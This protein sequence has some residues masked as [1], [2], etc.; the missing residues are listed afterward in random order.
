M[1]Y[2]WLRGPIPGFNLIKSSGTSYSAN[3]WKA[4]TG[5]VSFPMTM[6]SLIA[7]Y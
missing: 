6:L 4:I 5:L 1:L 7:T 2:V 3:Q